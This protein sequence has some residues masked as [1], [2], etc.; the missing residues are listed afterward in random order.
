MEAADVTPPQKSGEKFYILI[1]LLLLAAGGGVVYWLVTRL[2]NNDGDDDGPHPTPTPTPDIGKWVDPS[3]LQSGQNVGFPDDTA[4]GTD[5]YYWNDDFCGRYD[6]QCQ[7]DQPTPSNKQVRNAQDCLKFIRDQHSIPD[8]SE[9]SYSYITFK[10]WQTDKRGTECLLG[11][12]TCSGD[13]CMLDTKHMLQ[14]CLHPP[15]APD[16]PPGS[17]LLINY[18]ETAGYKAQQG[19]CAV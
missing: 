9:T 19:N 5:V 18:S 13:G 8:G 2:N 3:K 11:T 14:W 12:S 1:L 4:S 15:P 6:M 16:L 10:P 17:E 7:P